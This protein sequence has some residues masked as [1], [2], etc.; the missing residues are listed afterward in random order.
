M[1][2]DQNENGGRK[3]RQ[4]DPVRVDNFAVFRP[5]TE[6]KQAIA[7]A[8]LTIGDCVQGLVRLLEDGHKVTLGYRAENSAYYLHLREGNVDW[9]KGVTVSCW[10]STLERVFQMMAYAIVHR[11]PEFPQV[12]LTLGQMADDW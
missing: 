6:E 10:H 1:G 2:R 5:T 7:L 9:D 8:N 4:K 12:Q 3:A 11:Y